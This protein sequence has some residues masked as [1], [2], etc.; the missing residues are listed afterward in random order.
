MNYVISFHCVH[1][2][3]FQPK[4]EIVSYHNSSE[5]HQNLKGRNFPE[6]SYYNILLDLFRSNLLIV[7]QMLMLSEF[8]QVL[9]FR[10]L[11]L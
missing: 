10:K 1:S 4:S 5:Y 6:T 11:I 9:S 7:Q 8:L 2:F 3:L